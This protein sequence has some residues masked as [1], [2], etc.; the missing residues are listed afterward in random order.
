[1]AINIY[2][3]DKTITPKYYG[4]LA[5]K[6][7]ST[8]T[9]F[10]VSLLIAAYSSGTFA[11]DLDLLKINKNHYTTDGTLYQDLEGYVVVVRDRTK[12]EF[13][14][15]N[16]EDFDVNCD[17]I[18][19]SFGNRRALCQSG[20]TYHCSSLYNYDN[21]KY[22][23]SRYLELAPNK[24][25]H[26]YARF[27]SDNNAGKNVVAINL[28]FFDLTPFPNRSTNQNNWKPL[29][30]EACGLNLGTLRSDVDNELYSDFNDRQKTSSGADDLPFGTLT[31]DSNGH[32]SWRKNT[33]ID[34][35]F[36]PSELGFSGVYLRYQGNDTPRSIWPEFVIEKAD[37]KVARTAVGFKANSPKM[38]FLV[39]QGGRGSGAKG[40]SISDVKK[41]FAVTDDYDYVMLLDGSGSSQLAANFDH[42]LI[43]SP[44]TADRSN[45]IFSAVKT[46][47]LQGD[48]VE[49][50][51]VAHWDSKY[52]TASGTTHQLV[53][54][55]TPNVLIIMD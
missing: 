36:D 54:R 33:N 25:V 6:K 18:H 26:N 16:L 11:A 50:A 2:I 21:N 22:R 14:I 52:K 27:Y 30:Q 1:L 13:E 48:K 31:I 10:G 5:M 35:N 9:S 12:V 51:Y 37:D 24:P 17:A 41:F 28:G 15:P 8:L 55:R 23:P 32:R 53:D 47:T 43:T 7:N 40:L 49:N 45:C 39:V 42:S 3:L 44:T 4:E 46:C 38:K 20:T 34:S 29:Y 19:S